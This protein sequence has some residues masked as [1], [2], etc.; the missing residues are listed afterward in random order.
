MYADVDFKSERKD[1]VSLGE[2]L[3]DLDPGGIRVT[4]NSS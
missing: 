4:H 1:L 2:Q 3:Q